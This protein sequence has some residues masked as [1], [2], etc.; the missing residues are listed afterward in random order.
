MP[1][2]VNSDRRQFLP[3]DWR[4]R[5]EERFKIDG[6]RCTAILPQTGDR[7]M[8]PA[9]ECDHIGK[10]TD[11]RIEM[12]RSLCSWCHAKKSSAEGARARQAKLDRNNMKFRR[13][14][15]HPSL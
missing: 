12:L 11:H 13:T 6:Y 4:Q 2:W 1:G 3:P 10:R 15:D 5:R 9:E 14:E 7:C 8:G